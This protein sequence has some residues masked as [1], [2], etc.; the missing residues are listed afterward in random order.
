MYASA[1]DSWNSLNC[2]E[3]NNCPHVLSCPTYPEH[4]RHCAHVA[5]TLCRGE[6]QGFYAMKLASCLNCDYY[7][8]RHYDR[9]YNP[10]KQEREREA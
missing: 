5:G 6:T 8:S 4:G 7:N 3:F 9:R 1:G 10:W 2:W